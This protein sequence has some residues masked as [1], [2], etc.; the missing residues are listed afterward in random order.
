[1]Q[2]PGFGRSRQNEASKLALVYKHAAI[3]IAASCASDDDQG[4]LRKRD[5]LGIQPLR[6]RSSKLLPDSSMHIDGDGPR[7]ESKE[8]KLGHL[9]DSGWAFQEFLL[10]RRVIDFAAQ[11]I[12]WDCREVE[13]NEPWPAG[14]HGTFGLSRPA[15][16]PGAFREHWSASYRWSEVVKHYSS[17]R[18]TYSRDKLPAISVLAEEMARL[19]GNSLGPYLA[20][21]WQSN[22]LRELCWHVYDESARFPLTYRASSWSWASLDAFVY[23]TKEFHDREDPDVHLAE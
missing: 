2:L 5:A 6:L 4:F 10:S 7:D 21:I 16:Y 8:G 22:I 9:A 15:I 19:T 17:R 13:A 12:H 23:N 20:G 3:T 11:Q 18:L 1:M 14:R